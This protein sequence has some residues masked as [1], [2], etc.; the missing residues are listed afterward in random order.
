MRPKYLILVVLV[1]TIASVAV[2][3]LRRTDLAS[4]PR[5]TEETPAEVPENA[6]SPTYRGRADKPES[7]SPLPSQ[8]PQ[9]ILEELA[10]NRGV[11]LNV[12]T[13]EALM[14]ASNILQEMRRTV[15]RPIEF[16]GKVAL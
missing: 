6:T 15:N 1:V 11:P 3:R 8:D 5:E 9:K 13:Q 4:L 12:L 10:R 16:Y 2:W 14:H 7:E